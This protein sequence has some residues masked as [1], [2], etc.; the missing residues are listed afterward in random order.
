MQDESPSKKRVRNDDEHNILDETPR[1]NVLQHRPILPTTAS[2]PKKQK[3]SPKRRTSSSPVKSVGQLSLLEKPIRLASIDRLPPDVDDL[4]DSILQAHLQEF[5]PCEVRDEFSILVK[6]SE[7]MRSIPATWFMSGM[8]S[9]APEASNTPG[10]VGQDGKPPDHA[11]IQKQRALQ[12]MGVLLDLV[13]EAAACHNLRRH[14]SAWNSGV[15]HP[16]LRLALVDFDRSGRCGHDEIADHSEDPAGHSRQL[17]ETVEKAGGVRIRVEN[18]TSATIAGDCIPQLERSV[19]KDATTGNF[20]KA[21]VVG[22]PAWSIS[23]VSSSTASNDGLDDSNLDDPFVQ[24]SG[25]AAGF[26]LDG[27]THTRTGSK[28][29]DFALVIEPSA[30]SSLFTAIQAVRRR[31]DDTPSQ[32]IN[33]STYSPLLDAPIAVIIE[34]KTVTTATD[35]IIQLGIMAIA[36]HRRLHTLPVKGARMTSPVT[37][38]GV[39]MTLPLIAVTDHQWELYFA[40]DNGNNVVRISQVLPF[41]AGSKYTNRRFCRRWWVLSSWALRRRYPRAISFC[42]VCDSWDHGLP[43]RTAR[44]WKPG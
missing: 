1:G 7:R 34:T 39:L 13:R 20:Q 6:R 3:R 40:R 41:P 37:T 24:D 44:P 4:Y 10:V 25:A 23:E 14:E 21:P 5:V 26:K 19:R 18:V 2:T 15:H 8:H 16:L 38:T 22:V 43:R 30:G 35:P 17:R 12:E 11:P 36:I 9:G 33:P 31:L 32:S 28:K 27:S 42:Y 29:V